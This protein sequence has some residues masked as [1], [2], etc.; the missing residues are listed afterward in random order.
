MTKNNKNKKDYQGW[1]I[2]FR[3]ALGAAMGL[4]MDNL[5][6]GIVGGLLFGIAISWIGPNKNKK[7]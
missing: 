3:L 5:L 7:E 6:I 1:G 2:G 4:L